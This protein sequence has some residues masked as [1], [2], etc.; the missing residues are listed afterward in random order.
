MAAM[1][2]V[3]VGEGRRGKLYNV[4]EPVQPMPQGTSGSAGPKRLGP[5]TSLV[6]PRD[7]PPDRGDG[8]EATT[9]CNARWSGISRDLQPRVAQVPAV[10]RVEGCGAGLLRGKQCLQS[11][12]EGAPHQ[13]SGIR[14]LVCG[15]GQEGTGFPSR[16]PNA[17]DGRQQTGAAVA[18]RATNAAGPC[19]FTGRANAS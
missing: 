19:R 4:G 12:H 5:G 17:C 11:M 13:R 3:P 15:A 1:H 14:Q 16:H 8:P 10:P 6:A 18:S 9:E 2:H 7:A